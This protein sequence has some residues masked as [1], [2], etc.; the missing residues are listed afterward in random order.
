MQTYIGPQ[1]EFP[2]LTES[3]QS[4]DV[5]EECGVSFLGNGIIET[6]Q[7]E[8]S[9]LRLD[10]GG[11]GLLGLGSARTA[12][13]LFVDLVL[14]L[15]ESGLGEDAGKNEARSCAVRQGEGVEHRA[16]GILRGSSSDHHRLRCCR[17]FPRPKT[18]LVRR[19]SCSR[20]ASIRTSEIGI[21]RSSRVSYTRRTTV[22]IMACPDEDP[23]C[24]SIRGLV[25]L[26]ARS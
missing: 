21:Q 6:R 25:N 23:P 20:I 24:L 1:I 9:V 19:I 11:F 14:V 3:Q 2:L 8:D 10:D 18:L 15:R 5:L 12:R 13:L 17:P 16:V 26:R 4:K 22:A 7:V